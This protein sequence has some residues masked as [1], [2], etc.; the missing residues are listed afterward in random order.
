[1]KIKQGCIYEYKDAFA[2]YDVRHVELLVVWDSRVAVESRLADHTPT[3]GTQRYIVSSEKMEEI[4]DHM[5][6]VL[7]SE[8]G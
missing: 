5:G 3:E 7:V 4:L 8:S 2:P 6:A 1:M